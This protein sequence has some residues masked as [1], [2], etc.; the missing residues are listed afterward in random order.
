MMPDTKT[1]RQKTSAEG[2]PF[3]L[4][5]LS[6]AVGFLR[7]LRAL[8]LQSLGAKEPFGDECNPLV[9]P[10]LAVLP[11]RVGPAAI[12]SSG[13]LDPHPPAC[14][15]IELRALFYNGSRLF[16]YRS[17][18]TSHHED[19]RFLLFE[20]DS[21]AYHPL[22]VAEEDGRRFRRDFHY[23]LEQTGQ[24]FGVVLRET[25]PRRFPASPAPH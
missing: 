24:E 1:D 15:R 13:F 16:E 10:A 9:A 14:E 8:G 11:G 4:S 19:W 21:S 6:L 2:L 18:L 7:L 12:L 23:R 20:G 3:S 22:V 17:D 25:P 5:R